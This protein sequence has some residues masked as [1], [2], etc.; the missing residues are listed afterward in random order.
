MKSMEKISMFR[1]G[2]ISQMARDGMYSKEN[3]NPPPK[4]KKKKRSK[5][6]R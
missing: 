4:K 6:K 1:M 2:P 5:R 3:V